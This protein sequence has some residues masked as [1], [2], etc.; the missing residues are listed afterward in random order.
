MGAFR[1]QTNQDQEQKRNLPDPNSQQYRAHLSRKRRIKRK[2]D[3]DSENFDI[4]M[5]QKWPKMI[6]EQR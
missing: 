5:N 6:L 2:Q 3:E 1:M 4:T